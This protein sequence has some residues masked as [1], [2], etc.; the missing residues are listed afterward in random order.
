VVCPNCQSP[1]ASPLEMPDCKT[2]RM[3]KPPRVS[4]G[5]PLLAVPKQGLLLIVPRASLTS[6]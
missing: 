6:T 1:R 4:R 3:T 5:L 2:H